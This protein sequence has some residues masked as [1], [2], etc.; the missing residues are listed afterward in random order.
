MTNSIKKLWDT[1]NITPN[2]PIYC[3][4]F[5]FFSLHRWRDEGHLPADE[6]THWY[7]EYLKNLLEFDQGGM[8]SFDGMGWCEA[9]FDPMF[10]EKV[11][12]DRG[13]HELE[14]DFAGR[15]VLYFKGRRTGF[16]P[17]YVDHPVKDDKTWEELCEWR[18]N[19]GSEGRFRH[20]EG[21]LKDIKWGHENGSMVG[22]R[23][24]G[25]YMYLRSLVGPVDLLYMFYDNP[26]LI[27]KMMQNWL[28]LGDVV[29]AKHQEY[30]D[31]DEIMFGEDICFNTGPL[32]SH[33]MIKEFLMPYYQ[34]ML[35]N[36][37]RRQKD[38][39]KKLFIQ[40][41]TDGYAPSVIDLYSKEMGM[42][43]MSPFE[44]ASN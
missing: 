14:Q 33:D 8:V 20:L 27:H 11:L 39:S 41:D 30:S 32:I 43:V 22:Q 4:E 18:L 40:V 12:E 26:G 3:K 36:L 29:I 23:V 28:E 6:K 44:V 5:G 34:Q 19:P 16:M 9:A 15:K 24:I 38:K 31:I 35:Q 13:E 2:A 1:Y 21:N 17:E 7:S 25:G 10:E 42:N 37:K